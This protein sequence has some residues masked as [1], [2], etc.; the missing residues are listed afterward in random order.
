LPYK[1]S[2]STAR[3]Y[4]CSHSSA[5]V[6]HPG[7]PA[8]STVQAVSRHI[9]AGAAMSAPRPS[10]LVRTTPLCAPTSVCLRALLRRASAA[11]KCCMRTNRNPE[12]PPMRRGKPGRSGSV[13]QSSTSG[14]YT[15]Q[16]SELQTC[17]VV[18]RRRAVLASNSQWCPCCC[19]SPAVPPVCGGWPDVAAPATEGL[20]M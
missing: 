3:C 2:Q 6:M 12:A 8:G 20:R 13:D 7:V 18:R 4:A 9:G 10:S 15:L 5:G 17:T 11:A 16:G 19:S 14:T 1:R